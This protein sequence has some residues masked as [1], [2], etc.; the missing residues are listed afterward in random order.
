MRATCINNALHAT[1]ILM[2]AT[3]SHLPC[4]LETNPTPTNNIT[5]RSKLA[6]RILLQSRWV[7]ALEACMEALWDVA[8]Q[9]GA[10]EIGIDRALRAALQAAQEL[11]GYRCKAA[12]R[13]AAP[14][15]LSQGAGFGRRKGEFVC[16]GDGCVWIAV[17][18]W[19]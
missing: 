16:M 3:H 12:P 11:C 1:Q 6:I 15:P 5:H 8:D 4:T 14:G 19:V 10:H 9:V 7:P 17:S 2:H 18:C 13:E